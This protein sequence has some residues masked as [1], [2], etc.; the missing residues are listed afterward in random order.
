MPDTRIR[1]KRWRL[2]TPADIT[3]LGWYDAQDAATIVQAT[4]PGRVSQWTDKGSVGTRHFLQGTAARQPTTGA[5]NING[6]NVIGFDAASQY[7]LAMG[8]NPFGATIS[9]AALFMVINVKSVSQAVTT[10]SMTGSATA[11]NRWQ[12]HCPWTGPTVYF[13][14]GGAS[15][16]NRVQY[17]SGWAAN[18]IRIMGFICSVT[19]SVQQIWE[20]GLLKIGDAT[21]HNVNTVGNPTLGAGAGGTEHDTCA[22]GECIIINGTVSTEIR[23]IIEGYLAWHWGLTGDLAESHP[24]KLAPP[25]LPAA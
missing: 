20:S 9:N 22:I 16:A 13:D 24:F 8:S 25:L 15:G 19:N 2:W 5:D 23:Q 21:G 10:F 14:C 1:F 4:T 17:G 3:T 7:F 12:S 18:T 11:A 6:F